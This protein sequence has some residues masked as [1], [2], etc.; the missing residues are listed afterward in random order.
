MWFLALFTFVGSFVLVGLSVFPGVLDQ[1]PP[2]SA[3]FLAGVAV[4]FAGGTSTPTAW[5]RPTT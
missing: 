1:I 2:A 3:R 5:C 4:L